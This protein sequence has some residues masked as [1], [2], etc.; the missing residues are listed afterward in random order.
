MGFGTGSFGV[1]EHASPSRTLSCCTGPDPS[2]AMA[3]FTSTPNVGPLQVAAPDEGKTLTITREE[4]ALATDPRGQIAEQFR[5]L[6]NS[7][8]ALNPEAAPRSVVVTSSLR[9]EGKSVAA[10]NLA[11]ALAEMPGIQVLLI[12]ANMHSPS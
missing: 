8:V 12:D 3:I 4:I 1:D 5:S 2:T 7:I 10:V 6:R 11:L 9:G